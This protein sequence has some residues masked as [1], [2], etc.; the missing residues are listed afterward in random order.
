MSDDSTNTIDAV[1]ARLRKGSGPDRDLDWDI[2]EAL[3][4][5]VRRVSGLGLNGRTPGQW[6]V[7][8]PGKEGT[9]GSQIPYYTKHRDRA[10]AKLKAARQSAPPS[11]GEVG[12]DV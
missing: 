7:F 8:W 11:Q 9:K 5:A 12:T 3:G 1:I 10:I 2:A 6:R 4:G